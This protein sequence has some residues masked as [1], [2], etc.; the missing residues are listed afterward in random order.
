MKKTTI[1]LSLNKQNISNLEMNTIS[2]GITGITCNIT[3]KYYE[4]CYSGCVPGP[5]FFD[6]FTINQGCPEPENTVLVCDQ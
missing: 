2:G 6:C 5:T 4:T 3:N 1:K